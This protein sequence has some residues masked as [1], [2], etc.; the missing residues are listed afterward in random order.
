[1]TTSPIRL[2]PRIAVVTAWLS[3]WTRARPQAR[4]GAPTDA[5]PAPFKSIGTGGLL[6][7]RRCEFAGGPAGPRTGGLRSVGG[8]TARRP[9][10]DTGGGWGARTAPGAAE[11]PP[12]LGEKWAPGDVASAENLNAK[13]S[14]LPSVPPLS[15]VRHWPLQDSQSSPRHV[16]AQA[17]WQAPKQATGIEQS[18]PPCESSQWQV[19]S[20]HN[21]RPLQ[22]LG[23]AG[24]GQPGPVVP[25]GHCGWEQSIPMWFGPQT[26]TPRMHKPCPE[27]SFK[28]DGSWTKSAFSEQSGCAHP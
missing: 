14:L 24:K 25:G 15:S 10:P 12:P 22:S 28:H 4:I 2:P 27:Q 19:P 26:H 18:G 11:D 9:E 23:Q 8:P 6:R 20:R 1:M 16:T 5:P 21:P 7:A 13:G 17:C 3:L